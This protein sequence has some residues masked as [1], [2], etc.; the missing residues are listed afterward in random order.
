MTGRT[1]SSHIFPPVFLQIVIPISYAQLHEGDE[2]SV[3]S[4]QSSTT[5]IVA[6]SGTPRQEPVAE[7]EDGLIK[8]DGSMQHCRG[9]DNVLT[10][11]Q[12]TKRSQKP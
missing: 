9:E 6:E 7:E 11:D 12:G 5:S 4:E 1:K 8:E 2:A 10:G 3:T